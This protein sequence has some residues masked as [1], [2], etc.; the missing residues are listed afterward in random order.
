M[1]DVRPGQKRISWYIPVAYGVLMS[2]KIASTY[3]TKSNLVRLKQTNT[4]VIH[5]SMDLRRSKC[6][7]RF[8]ETAHPMP[9]YISKPKSSNL[10][11]Y[12][13]F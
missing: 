10:N 4:E 3:S 2:E 1:Y 8:Q 13:L 12:A 9:E 11:G 5:Y 6:S 7:R